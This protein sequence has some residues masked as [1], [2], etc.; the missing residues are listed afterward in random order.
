MN[1]LY[2][3][4]LQFPHICTDTRNITPECLFFCL[5]GDNFDGNAFA[6][7]ALA[8][9]AARVVTEDRNLAS[10]ENCIVV[11]NVLKTLQALALY[12]RSQ[13]RIPVIGIT[14][15]NGKTTTKEL[16]M[17]VLSKK[18]RVTYT[19]GNFNNH[20]GVPLTLLAINAETEIA[21]VEMGA[22]HV[23]EI[24]DLCHIAQPTHG[25]ITNIGK[26]HLE[27]FGSIENIIA[28]K[29]AIYEFLMRHESTIFIN[30]E[31]DILRECV[32]KYRQLVKYGNTPDSTCQGTVSALNPYLSVQIDDLQFNT[33]LTGEYNLTNIL[34]AVA[35]GLHFGVPLPMAAQ[36]IADYQPRN[37][38]S[39]LS[40][41]GSNLIIADYYN[42]NPSS[43][44]AALVN[45]LHLPDSQKVA[46]LG[47]MLELG[48]AAI[49]EHQKIVDFC[50][51]NKILAF[52]VGKMFTEIDCP[53]AQTFE[54]VADLN[55]FLA[56]NPIQNS[57]ILIK[58]SRG[59]H[60]ETIILP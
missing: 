24:A 54:N 34:C 9:G 35:V 30:D 56:Q 21:I 40:R 46:I 28:T 4:Y 53:K 55:A 7:Q 19:Q 41:Q 5:K 1:K 25:L 47:E 29:R 60:L 50:R 38:R 2:D 51:Q 18:Y 27:G 49:E 12:H 11:D 3:I 36:A 42:A 31:D 16:I 8:A 39:Q 59:I 45:L 33:Q 14:G 48:E 6:L 52:F 44:H 17:S 58:G 32:G 10:H 22:N 26:A 13:L 15:T 43:M 23:G 20:I 57:T 37:N